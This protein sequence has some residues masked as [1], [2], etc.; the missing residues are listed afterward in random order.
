MR[1]VAYL[2]FVKTGELHSVTFI[3]NKKLIEK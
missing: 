2:A 3:V 1:A